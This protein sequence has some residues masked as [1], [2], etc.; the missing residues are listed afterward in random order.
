MQQ[1]LKLEK[2]KVVLNALK[3]S[4]VMKSYLNILKSELVFSYVNSHTVVHTVILLLY[5][6]MTESQMDY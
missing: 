2:K 6:I 5:L 3:L 4:R 1:K